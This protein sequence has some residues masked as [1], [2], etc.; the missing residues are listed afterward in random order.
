MVEEIDYKAKYQK[1]QEELDNMEQ[2][3]NRART[4]A[5]RIRIWQGIVDDLIKRNIELAEGIPDCGHC[6]YYQN[7]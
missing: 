1:C 3:C 4:D 5:K 2:Q 7:Y 6:R